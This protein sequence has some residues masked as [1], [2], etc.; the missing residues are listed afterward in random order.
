MIH[1]TILGCYAGL[2][3]MATVSTILYLY[4]LT[5]VVVRAIYLYFCLGQLAELPRS[6]FSWKMVRAMIL[7]RFSVLQR[8]ASRSQFCGFQSS[9]SK[10]GHSKHQIFTFGTYFC[11]WQ[12]ICW[13]TSASWHS[14]QFTLSV[15]AN[16]YVHCLD[17]YAFTCS[18]SLFMC[19]YIYIS[20]CLGKLL[21]R[22]VCT[23][24][25]ERCLWRPFIHIFA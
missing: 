7:S 3:R 8:S 5:N 16:P 4:L 22:P 20:I 12:D 25:Y 2:A 18:W 21:G 19:I 10:S 15:G 6:W 13:R 17:L 11:I 1:C 9:A 23:F 24:A 14:I